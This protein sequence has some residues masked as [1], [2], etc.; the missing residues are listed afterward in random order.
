MNFF[1]RLL[2]SQ[3]SQIEP[4]DN[5]IMNKFKKINKEP[6]RKDN[7]LLCNKIYEET[8]NIYSYLMESIKGFHNIFQQN[9]LNFEESLQYLEKI[10]IP[11]KCV[12]AGVISNI[13]GWRCVDCSKY[14][15]TIYCHN[16][17]VKSKDLHKNHNVVFLY[18]SSGMCDC[19]DPDALKIYCPEHSGPYT[20]QNQIDAYISKIFNKDILEKLKTFFETLF[21]KFSKY[22]ILTE[23]FEYFSK[24]LFDAKFNRD[25]E[26]KNE[27]ENNDEASDILLLKNNFGV[28]FQNLLTF[29]RLISEKNL[30]ML[31]LIANYFLKNHLENQKLEDEYMT[32][33]QCIKIAQNDIQLFYKDKQ[34][35]ICVCPFAR[36]FITNYRDNVECQFENQEFLLSFS[37]NL[38]LRTAFCILIF[39]TYRQL[40]L[41]NN[42][43][44]LGNR[45]HFYIED[46]L[47]LIAKKTEL[48]EGIY[49]SCYQI[50]LQ[51]FKSPKIK[52]EFGIINDSI[53]EKITSIIFFIYVDTKY[54]SKPKIRPLMS[55][56][57]LIMKRIID[58]ICLLHNLIE[59]KSIVPHP[60]FQDKGGSLN[61]IYLE[62]ILLNINKEIT[63]FI[64]WEKIDYLKDI[65]KYLINKILNQEKEGIK[66]LKEDEYTFHIGL[67]RCFGI[68]INSFCFNHSL[69]NKCNLIKSIEYFNKTFF[70]SNKQLEIFV[71]L[72]LKDYFKFFG[73]IAACKNNFFNYY[74]TLSIYSNLYSLNKDAYNVI[75]YITDFSLLKF[76]FIMS[77]K[78][79]D[80]ISYFKKS[81]IENVYSL[82]INSFNITNEKEIE[83]DTKNKKE[84]PLEETKKEDNNSEDNNTTNTEND[85]IAPNTNLPSIEM[86]RNPNNKQSF[87]QFMTILK[88]NNDKN[89]KSLDEY[90][91]IM[92]WKF[93]LDILI[94]FMKDDSSPYYNLL[95]AY[96][97]TVSS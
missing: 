56:K 77:Q 54:F 24:E 14:E 68:Y 94:S 71:D 19:G 87:R 81:N 46:A 83:N 4:Q 17:Y 64:E 3:N 12:C 50:I 62:L 34:K 67:Y 48:I 93:L 37:H 76:I 33:H 16:C 45:T 11:N 80:I 73:F 22:L 44:F 53:M 21:S 49:D 97:E 43:K 1:N 52:D 29:L 9:L 32:T 91:C 90:N 10:S 89:D 23:Q 74:D 70:E 30:G 66:Q 96:S 8:N 85:I 65:F 6:L 13:P 38:L 2:F 20:D 63:M 31:H 86:L 47:E 61:L 72:I 40:L 35:H 36:L 59:F 7:N 41:N 58:V 28:V 55:N 60:E 57:T 15:N 82:F 88:H 26:N 95:S 84:T 75:Y 42:E 25:N 39:L 51:Y 5:N 27:N 78:K 92:Q 18:S 69:I 79:I